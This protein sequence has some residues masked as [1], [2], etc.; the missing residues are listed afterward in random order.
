VCTSAYSVVTSTYTSTY[1]R[2]LQGKPVATGVDTLVWPI[3][4]RLSIHPAWHIAWEQSELTMMTPKPPTLVSYAFRRIQSRECRLTIMK[5]SNMRIPTWTPGQKIRDGQYDNGGYGPGQP[6]DNNSI[7]G[8]LFYFVTIGVPIIFGFLIIFACYCCCCCCCSKAAR[9]QRRE[10]RG[11]YSKY[12]K[13]SKNRNQATPL[14]E[15]VTME[16]CASV[17]SGT[18]ERVSQIRS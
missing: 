13:G 12:L 10:E 9:K 11:L 15:I 2:T 5:T 17:A 3:T 8:A 1:T 14:A 4:A 18:N 7:G 16:N 6:R